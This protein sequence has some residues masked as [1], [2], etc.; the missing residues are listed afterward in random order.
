[1][2]DGIVDASWPLGPYLIDDQAFAQDLS[3][4]YSAIPQ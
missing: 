4:S 1:M 2:P 3:W